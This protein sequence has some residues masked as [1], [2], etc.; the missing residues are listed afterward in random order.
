MRTRLFSAA[1]LSLLLAFALACGGGASVAPREHVTALCGLTEI[2]D[3]VSLVRTNE[4][5]DPV[6][7]SVPWVGVSAAGVLIDGVVVDNQTLATELQ[8]KSEAMKLFNADSSARLVLLAD[9]GTPAS[10]ALGVLSAASELGFTH[11]HVAFESDDRGDQPAAPDPDYEAQL[12]GRIHGVPASERAF[13]LATELSELLA[14]C[15]LGLEMFTA[16][17][18]AVPE[19]KCPLIAAGLEEAL[20]SCPLTN[21]DKVITAVQVMLTPSTSRQVVVVEAPIATL[22]L[23]SAGDASW[24]EVS[25]PLLTR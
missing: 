22:T 16:I 24:G 14:L 10:V 13:L 18:M 6:P 7:L 25:A 23:S 9:A 8:Q 15:P 12:R 2:P 4:P 11:V 19:H 5:H 17:A 3:G 20:P 1:C 21:G